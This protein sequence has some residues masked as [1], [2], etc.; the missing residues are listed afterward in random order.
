[1]KTVEIKFS[2]YLEVD[3]PDGLTEEEYEAYITNF[4]Q[5]AD[6][7]SGSITLDDYDGYEKYLAE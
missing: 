1:M 5:T 2:V 7:E 4:A 3:V 6:L